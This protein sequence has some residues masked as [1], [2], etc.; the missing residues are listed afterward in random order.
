MFEGGERSEPSGSDPAGWLTSHPDK[1]VIFRRN[2]CKCAHDE[3]E[4]HRELL[5]AIVWELVEFLGLQDEH[6]DELGLSGSE[7]N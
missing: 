4:L 2:L 3:Y 1:A 6:L 5:E 7:A